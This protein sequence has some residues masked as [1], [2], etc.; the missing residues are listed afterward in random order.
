MSINTSVNDLQSSSL[1]I[2]GSLQNI[3]M[4][5]DEASENCI[6]LNSAPTI[7]V[8]CSALDS[9]IYTLGAN[10]FEVSKQ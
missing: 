6:A 4:A 5:L 9:S 7:D 10:F 8:D 2:N 1:S 3:T